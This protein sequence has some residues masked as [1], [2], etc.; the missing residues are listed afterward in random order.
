MFFPN[1]LKNWWILLAGSGI[2]LL[3]CAKYLYKQNEREVKEKEED[4]DTVNTP[5][6]VV[7]SDSNQHLKKRRSLTKTEDEKSHIHGKTIVWEL[8]TI[9]EVLPPGETMWARGEIIGIIEED[10]YRVRYF[11]GAT[12]LPFFCCLV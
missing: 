3:C 4:D 8:K 9:V 11:H 6:L 5:L 1:I 7:L 2:I 12:G 10:T